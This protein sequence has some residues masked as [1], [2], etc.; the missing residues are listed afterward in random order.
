MSEA[1]RTEQSR[2]E[3]DDAP[4][5]ELSSFA[6]DVHPWIA[7]CDGSGSI[8]PFPRTLLVLSAKKFRS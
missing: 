6:V 7:S 5:S 1:Q 4:S 8:L 2:Q 3:E